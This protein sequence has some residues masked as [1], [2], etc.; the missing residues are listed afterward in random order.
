MGFEV[1]FVV[2][3]LL[4]LNVCVLSRTGDCPPFAA[5]LMTRPKEDMWLVSH[6]LSILD[7]E[8]RTV[9]NMGVSDIHTGEIG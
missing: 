9:S 1:Y 4:I 3:C 6:A 5:A 7:G 8:V 2:T